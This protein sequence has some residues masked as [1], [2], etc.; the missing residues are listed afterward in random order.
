MYIFISTYVYIHMYS[1]IY[2]YIY[3]Y[4]YIYIH[5]HTRTYLHIHTLIWHG[6]VGRHESNSVPYM[7]GGGWQFRCFRA[8][9]LARRGGPWHSSRAKFVGGGRCAGKACARLSALGLPTSSFGRGCDSIVKQRCY[10]QCVVVHFGQRTNMWVHQTKSI[11]SRG[12]REC[13]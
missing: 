8:T 6:T 7:Q 9:L 13:S 1:Y 4:I 12:Y 2:T 3:T 5:I 10:H 11:S